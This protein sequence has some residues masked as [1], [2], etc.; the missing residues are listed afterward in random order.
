M[1][2]IVILGMYVY[3]FMISIGYT[4]GR[5]NES[6]DFPGMKAPSTVESNGLLTMYVWLAGQDNPP[7]YPD[8]PIGEV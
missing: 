2:L 5:M 3:G 1:K 4:T 7:P 6:M 8:L